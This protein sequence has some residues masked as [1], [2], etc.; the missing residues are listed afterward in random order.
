MNL[1]YTEAE[2]AFRDEVRTFVRTNLPPEISRKI[3]E[4]KRLGKDDWA[5]PSQERTRQ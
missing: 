1:D 3:I 2:L 5:P 4:H